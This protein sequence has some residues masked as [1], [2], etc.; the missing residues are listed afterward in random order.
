MTSTKHI[1]RRAVAL[2]IDLFVVLGLLTLAWEYQPFVQPDE[3]GN[4][5]LGGCALIAACA[6]FWWLYFAAAEGLWAQTFGKAIVGL[7]VLKIDGSK[8]TLF[9]CTKRHLLDPIEFQLLGLPA[10]I[11]AG[12]SPTGRRLGDLLAGTQVV[13]EGATEGT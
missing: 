13:K 7:R 10:A 9:D 8:A 12:V 2:L 5:G 6:A 4:Y 3:T 11:A 1:G